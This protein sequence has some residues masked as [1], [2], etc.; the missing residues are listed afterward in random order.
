MAPHLNTPTESGA[1]ALFLCSYLTLIVLFVGALGLGWA[2][3]PEPSSGAWPMPPRYG[4]LFRLTFLGLLGAL[5]G[6]P[7]FFFLAPKLALFSSL[8]GAGSWGLL[9]F[10]SGTLLA[11]WYVYWQGA[12][13]LFESAGR[14]LKAGAPLTRGGALALTLA[15]M[16]PL[17]LSGFLLDLWALAQWLA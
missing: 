14:P 1:L 11:G 16:G 2:L 12:S 8:V 10:L 3:T 6:F 17:A 5:G 13:G 9:G 4:R 15:L 7:P